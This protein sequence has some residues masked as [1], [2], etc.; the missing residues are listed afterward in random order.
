M[1]KKVIP[2]VLVLVMIVT[3]AF[4]VSAATTVYNLNDFVTNVDIDGEND[5]M[6]VVIPYELNRWHT[7]WWDHFGNYIKGQPIYNVQLESDMLPDEEVSINEFSVVYLPFG[8]GNYFDVSSLPF[9]T[10]FTLQNV[11]LY[12]VLNNGQGFNTDV[13]QTFS[14]QY[15]DENY[16]YISTQWVDK[17][18]TFTPGNVQ[19]FTYNLE[20]VTFTL[21]KPDGAK[22]AW[23][24]MMLN[25]DAFYFHQ[26]FST[27]SVDIGDFKFDMRISSAYREMLQDQENQRLLNEV[28][29]QLEE[30]NMTM[31]EVLEQ[32]QANGEKLDDLKDAIEQAPQKEHDA[33]TDGG[34]KNIGQVL[35]VIPN[36][37]AGF[38]EALSEFAESFS[39]NG[40]S[41]V[42]PIPAITLP[43]IPGLI[44]SFT[45]MDE[46]EIDFG[47][48][49]QLLPET[50][51]LLVQSLLTIALIVYCFKELYDTIAYVMTL[52]RGS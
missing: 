50:L 38:M 35:D 33:A 37:S 5:L 22:Y 42:L 12:F 2:L 43:E 20:D 28:N 6:T 32:E 46:Q 30:Q 15:Y 48:Y 31:Q 19:T 24:R 29:E 51:L 8:G 34:N 52:R 1:L 47:V 23:F 36:E 39:Y 7:V 9:S 16:N 18:Y 49:V 10:S 40:T 3:T 26:N 21:D 27:L 14:V 13:L 41:A 11:V 25:F 4:P 17:E 45:I 44:P